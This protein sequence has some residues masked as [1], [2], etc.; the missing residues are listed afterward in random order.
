MAHLTDMEEL[1]ATIPGS[2]IRDYMREAMS[3]YM[4]SAYRGSLVLSYIA[5]FDDL[6]AKL[7][8]LANVNSSAKTIYVEATKKKSEQEVYESYL[9]DQLTSKNLITGLDASFLTT[10]RTLRNKSAHPS[11]HKPSPEEA[12]FIFFE[13]IKRFLS[14]PILSTTQLVDELISRLKNTNFFPSIVVLDIKTVVADETKNLHDEAIPQ[15]VAK[16][17]SAVTSLDESIKKNSSLFLV[18]LATNDKPATVSALQSRLIA[19]KADDSAFE[20]L[21]TQVLS[22]NGKLFVGLNATTVNRIRAVLAKKITDTTGAVSESKLI[23][24][25]SALASI[26]TEVSETQFVTTFKPELEAL[27]KK[28]PHSQ[29]VIKLVQDKPSLLPIYFP[30]LL[31]N[32]G[33]SD[34]GTA[35]A[36][37][38][39]VESLDQAL[40]TLLSDE[41]AFELIIA[42]MKAASCGA[43]SAKGVAT[44]KFAGTPL[45]RAKALTYISTNNVG[46]AEKIEHELS[47]SKP[48]DCFVEA[49]LTD[50]SA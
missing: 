27:F 5:L 43:W 35:N 37:S 29:F 30:L 13:T 32:A 21:L 11:G 8:E 46:A 18:G 28:R 1:L 4:A 15:L 20:D 12:R 16:L 7:G 3:C 22:A 6:L 41:H 40:S 9:I 39:A 50:E 47:E 25:I 14:Q 10:L 45:L 38:N 19:P 2:D 17:V 33:S 42:I 26:A 23:H 31:V 24:P 36:F 49:S 48:I 34:F 44:A